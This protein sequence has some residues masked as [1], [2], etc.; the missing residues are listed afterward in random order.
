MKQKT[1]VSALGAGLAL[2]FMAAAITTTSTAAPPPERVLIK[3]KQ[4]AKA[5]V[6]TALKGAN[7]KIHYSFDNIG[8]FAATVPAQALNG[9]RNN[10]NVE[11][12]EA[13]QIRHPDA[14]EVP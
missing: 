3:F 7:A 14:Q 10:P 11:F 2:T 12:V 4:G 13:D 1:L 8:L 9:L 5:A 6:E